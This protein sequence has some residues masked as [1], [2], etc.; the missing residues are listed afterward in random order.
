MT[1]PKGFEPSPSPGEGASTSVPFNADSQLV[2]NRDSRDE[3]RI[4]KEVG[5]I[6]SRIS[7]LLDNDLQWHPEG[8][9]LWQKAEKEKE[10]LFEEHKRRSQTFVQNKSTPEEFDCYSNHYRYDEYGHEIC[11]SSTHER[12][13]NWC[14][15]IFNNE[16]DSDMLQNMP[17]FTEYWPLWDPNMLMTP[18]CMVKWDSNPSDLRLME[19][20]MIARHDERF[21]I[22]QLHRVACVFDSRGMI[23]RWRIPQG[24][25]LY[26]ESL[27]GEL[28]VA[29]LC[30]PGCG[31]YVLGGSLMVLAWMREHAG[32]NVE[33]SNFWFISEGEN[34]HVDLDGH[35]VEQCL[36]STQ[37]PYL[38]A[39]RLSDYNLPVP[40]QLDYRY[41]CWKTSE[42]RYVGKAAPTSELDAEAIL[43]N[44]VCG[45][46]TEVGHMKRALDVASFDDLIAIDHE[47]S[48]AFHWMV[49]DFRNNDITY[50]L[51][52]RPSGEVRSSQRNEDFAVVQSSW[53][54]ST[55]AFTSNNSVDTFLPQRYSQVT[56]P[57]NHTIE[58]LHGYLR[59][60]LSKH[61]HN[62]DEFPD[63]TSTEESESDDSSNQEIF[64]Q[65]TLRPAAHGARATSS[66]RPKARQPSSV[67]RGGMDQSP[68]PKRTRHKP[69]HTLPT[70]AA[71]HRPV[72]KGP[73]LPT[74]GIGASKKRGGPPALIDSDGAS[75]SVDPPRRQPPP[76]KAELEHWTNP[77]KVQ[78]KQPRHRPTTYRRAMA[79]TNASTTHGFV[80]A[81]TSTHKTSLSEQAKEAPEHEE[82]SP[83]PRAAPS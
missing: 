25:S 20:V 7:A 48:E 61:G 43:R 82:G 62:I 60:L 45:T 31:I 72:R 36:S 71:R 16:M 67:Q 76:S 15:T 69:N 22:R 3:G 38:R 8:S 26:F 39:I 27:T 24:H 23:K 56:K 9:A 12:Q 58:H 4:D 74:V 81:T 30:V 78:L 50:T 53:K 55:N 47:M 73:L 75:K 34:V 37:E 46:I 28:Y 17:R 11:R 66:H 29:A 49:P 59:D 44:W 65:R 80:A 42:M 1:T 64:A 70:V 40:N 63:N 14:P 68:M 13:S 6:L 77:Y 41:W 10:A 2:T 51:P 79:D 5:R 32:Q 33:V 54:V 19:T 18:V 57:G 52:S 21:D 83:E 35:C